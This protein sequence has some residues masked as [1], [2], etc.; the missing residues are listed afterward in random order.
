[1]NLKEQL[2]E[3]MKTAAKAKDKLKLST[4][5][6]VRSEIKNREIALRHE[7]NDDEVL[8]LLGTMVKQRKDSISQFKKGGREDLAAKE[9]LELKILGVYLPEPMNVAEIE[10]IV[11]T[12]IAETGAT[13][14]KDMGKV[15]QAVMARVAGRADGKEVNRMVSSQLS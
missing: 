11:K 7:V 12:V 6:M 8:K 1:M 10:N 13:G 9:E 15:M 2:T 4:I 5:R 3:E 14:K